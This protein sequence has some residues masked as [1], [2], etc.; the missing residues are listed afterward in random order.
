MLVSCS[1]SFAGCDMEMDTWAHADVV[2][3]SSQVASSIK[4]NS[5]SAQFLRTSN[6]DWVA[7]EC[8]SSAP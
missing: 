8:S 6:L 3:C 7:R 4:A 2:I 1:D 5:V